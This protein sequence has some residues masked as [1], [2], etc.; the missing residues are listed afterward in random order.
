MSEKE[1]YACPKF[2]KIKA[3]WALIERWMYDVS[4]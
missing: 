4:R 1:V 3:R 2:V